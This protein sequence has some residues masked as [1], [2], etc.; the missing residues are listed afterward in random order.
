MGSM[1]GALLVGALVAVGVLVWVVTLDR[2]PD[3]GTDAA[4]LHGE[5]EASLTGSANGSG[6]ALQGTGTAAGDEALK[7]TIPAPAPVDPSTLDPVRDIFG[8]VV[9]VQGEPVA[10]ATVAASEYTWRSGLITASGY[11]EAMQFAEARTAT[12]GSFRLRIRPGQVVA[13]L[14]QHAGYA[15]T[16]VQSVSGGARLRVVL[17]PG[18]RLVLT[19][20][21]P[22][23]DAAADVAV[24]IWRADREGGSTS[25][26][27]SQSTGPDGRVVFEGLP[28]GVAAYLEPEPVHE[29]WGRPSW[30][31]INLQE[32]GEQHYTYRLPEGRTLRGLVTDAATGAPIEGARVG[33]NWVLDGEV[34][35]DGDGHYVL[36]GWTGGG[37]RDIQVIAKGY[38]RGTAAVADRSEIDF[39]LQHGFSM[40]GR[41][42]DDAGEPIQHARVATVGSEHRG[43]EQ[44][45]SLGQAMTGPEGTFEIA[46]LDP[47]LAHTIQA[48][49]LEYASVMLDVDAVRADETLDVGHIVLPRPATIEGRVIDAEGRP[50][51]RASVTLSSTSAGRSSRRTEGAL[52][53]A[54]YEGERDAEDGH[55]GALPCCRPG[56][57]TW[58]VDRFGARRRLRDTRGRGADVRERATSGA[59]CWAVHGR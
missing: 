35:T 44:A 38:V 32:S 39:Q 1:R 40:R 6:P 52:P 8:I 37:V 16:E 27:R 57:R 48:R 53:S 7:G 28:G 18:V 43:S 31:A 58:T 50:Y 10:G 24:G 5:A 11:Y 26:H 15:A 19:L 13:V 45:I 41:V 17:R 22:D 46:G 42:V 56:P 23:G 20:E 36:P 4:T 25:F 55:A 47:T 51:E 3:L 49:A 33:M 30:V 2:A 12:D 29:G 21:A 34:K 14:V 59:W 54:S 9:D